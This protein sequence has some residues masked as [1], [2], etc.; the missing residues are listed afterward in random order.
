MDMALSSLVIPPLILSIT[1]PV[2]H[3]ILSITYPVSHVTHKVNTNVNI[4]QTK[5]LKYEQNTYLHFCTLY[6]VRAK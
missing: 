3:V 2:S 6:N 5:A 4:K 1:Y